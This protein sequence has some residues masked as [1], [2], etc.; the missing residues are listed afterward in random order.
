MSRAFTKRLPNG[1]GTEFIDLSQ[2]EIAPEILRLIPSG[3]A[4]LHGALPIEVSETDFAG[5]ARR[6]V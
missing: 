1:L 2:H 3:L 5:R 4:R 6:S